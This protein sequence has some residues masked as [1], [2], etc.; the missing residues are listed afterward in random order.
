MLL[1]LLSL[2]FIF[3]LLAT[4]IAQA[5]SSLSASSNYLTGNWGG[6]RSILKNK[7]VDMELEYTSTYQGLSAGT[8]DS[9][10][11]YG[12]K[13]D[14]FITLDSSKLQLWQGGSLRTHFEYRHGNDNAFKGGA[15]WPT[16]SAQALPL[17]APN[18]LVASS[19]YLT[20]QLS[21]NI[22]LLLGKINVLDLL[23]KDNF[24]GGWGNHRFMNVA[25][26]A[27][28]SGVLPPTIFGSIMN[29]KAKNINW[30][31]M[32]FDPND[33]TLDYL[34][35]DLFNEGINVSFS[36]AKSFKLSGRK[37]N[38][39]AGLTYSTQTGADLNDILLPPELESGTKE[40]S[41]SITAQFSHNLNQDE[42]S[43]WGIFIKA[44]IADGNPNPID[45]SIIGGI[46]GKA[47]FIN[48]AQDNFGIGYFYYAVSNELREAIQPSEDLNDDS[49][50]EVFYNYQVSA[51]FNL[52]ADIQYI[53]PM[54]SKNKNA[55]VMGLRT[56]IKF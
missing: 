13:F 37:S 30:T 55:L 51:W 17:G 9:A 10:F 20:Q 6:V 2:L 22:S 27:P 47:A 38:F 34:P 29:I 24:F 52:T 41:Y 4:N 31:L 15:L 35:N 36:G 14:A 18:K 23:A 25:F 1:N 28:P 39:S 16:N 32:A 11:N 5:Q 40:G 3:T 48:R 7:G 53:D 56:N 8:G 46:G 50:L 26:V 12:G 33:R 54:K 42:A 45:A 21:P 44:S 19:L 49:G 43:P